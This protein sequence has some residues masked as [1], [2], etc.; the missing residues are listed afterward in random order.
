M[1]IDLEKHFFFL[2]QPEKGIGSNSHSCEMDNNIYVQFC[3]RAMLNLL[4][5]VIISS[6]DI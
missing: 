2:F 1:T 3:L 6:E 5:S 4:F